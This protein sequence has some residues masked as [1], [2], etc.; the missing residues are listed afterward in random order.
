MDVYLDK[1][2]SRDKVLAM[3]LKSSIPADPAIQRTWNPLATPSIQIVDYETILMDLRTVER[4]VEAA[5]ADRLKNAKTLWDRAVAAR[6]NALLQAKNNQDN[7][8]GPRA[9]GVDTSNAIA[10]SSGMISKSREAIDQANQAAALDPSMKPA[11]DDL[12]KAMGSNI[13]HVNKIVAQ[14]KAMDAQ[15]QRDVMREIMRHPGVF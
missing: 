9:N 3:Q 15:W 5:K 13:D 7:I 2:D 6:D 8:N 14:A 12:V 11:A 10:R 1:A 4:A